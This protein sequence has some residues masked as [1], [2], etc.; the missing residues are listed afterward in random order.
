MADR[1]VALREPGKPTYLTCPVQTQLFPLLQAKVVAMLVAAIVMV[2]ILVIAA[3]AIRH[4]D[5]SAEP[6]D[7]ASPQQAQKANS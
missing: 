1:Q 2:T 5:A 6:K 7:G 3:V 4:Q